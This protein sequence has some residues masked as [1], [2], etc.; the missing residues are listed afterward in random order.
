[1]PSAAD[2]RVAQRNPVRRVAAPRI[3]QP[4]IVQQ[5]RRKRM[6]LV[7][8]R[9][10]PQHMRQPRIIE[11]SQ[12]RSRDQPAA[13]RQR[14]HRLLHLA[15][16]RIAPERAVVRSQRAIDAHVKLVLVV[17]IVRGARVV[18]RRAA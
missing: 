18:I 9:L 17:G 3:A 15:V 11:R 16:I 4:Q 10:L 7:E 12:H 1:M 5:V 8:D 14:R 6:R 13:I 2:A